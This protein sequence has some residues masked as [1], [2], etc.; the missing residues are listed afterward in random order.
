MSD[1]VALA[2]Q[3]II[4]GVPM[5][6][7]YALGEEFQNAGIGDVA[8]VPLAGRKE[9]GWIVA[10]DTVENAELIIS[11]QKQGAPEKTKA[12]KGQIPPNETKR[13]ITL[14]KILKC[15]TA[16]PKKDFALFQWMSQYY[17]APLADII[18]GAIPKIQKQRKKVQTNQNADSE[19]VF[20]APASLNDHQQHAVMYIE[21]QLKKSVFSPMLLFG[22]TGSGKTEVYINAILKTLALGKSALLIVPEIALTP[23]LLD[24]FASRLK[25][26]VAVLHSQVGNSARWRAWQDILDGKTKVAIGARSAVF[27]PFENLGIIIVDE[28]HD[29]S[30]KQ[31]NKI[32]YNGRDVAIM[33]AKL[34]G[35]PVVLGS[36]TPSFESLFNAANNNY[37][38]LE[39]PSRA[40][41]NPLPE[42]ELVNLGLIKSK[43]MPSENISPRLHELLQQTLDK[44]EQAIILYNRRGFASY[45]QCN[46]CARVIQCPNCS[47]T[48][49]FHKKARRLMC[50]YC[51]HSETAAEYCEICRNPH[52]TKLE[53]TSEKELRKADAE[54]GLL[55]ER[56]GGTERVLEELENLFPTARIARMD[57]DTTQKKEA[58]KDILAS[59]RRREIDF[60]IG[61]Q[62]IAKG[63]DLPNVTLV[64]I[65][66]ADIGLHF[67]DFRA[68][69]K[70]F[71]LITQ[72]GGRAGR[73]MEPGRVVVQT[74]QP[75][76][77]TIVAVKTGRFKAFSRYELEYRK[78]LKYPP[79]NRLLRIVASGVNQ[80]T[81]AEYIEAVRD[82]MN[83]FL[84]NNSAA[85]SNNIDFQILG[86]APAPIQK[87]DKLYRQ[88]IL[89]KSSSA[90]LISEIAGMLNNYRHNVRKNVKTTDLR[91][92]I[93]VDPVDML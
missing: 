22:V 44:K 15:Q 9:N 19:F 8:T 5:P 17:G 84:K 72:A 57:R 29:S 66:D 41:N 10:I 75:N 52:S 21:Q 76:H 42:I 13:K 77:P 34:H 79:Y 27:A 1:A 78:T 37:S 90:K 36:A 55:K 85:A 56:G 35:C 33:K 32:Y 59:M 3:I 43:N 65:I 6:L 73:A 69:E 93:D 47:V 61:T 68:S 82:V 92:T 40:S 88:H 87:I 53:S 24:H 89:F 50:H 51:N 11:E 20:P 16:F 86:P 60:L 31:N 2:A 48:L 7:Y 45:L 28:E 74:R 80:Q 4:P 46:S 54:A 81:V 14:R 70:T 26:P 39:L 83:N 25:T 49:T 58:C 71:Q 12:K 67:P 38:L 62:M 64:G 91:L 23:Q 18:D 30:F 63:H